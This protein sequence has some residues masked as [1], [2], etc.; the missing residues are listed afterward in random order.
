MAKKTIKPKPNSLRTAAYKAKTVAIESVNKYAYPVRPPDILPGVVPKGGKAPVIAMDYNPGYGQFSQYAQTMVGF[1]GFSYLSML[2]TRPEYRAFAST[3]STE[4][5]R[6]WIEFTSKQDDDTDSNDKIKL[7][8]DEFKRLNVMGAI[9]TAAAHDCLFGRAQLFID[10]KGADRKTP[11]ILDPRTIKKDSLTR[12]SPVEAIWTTPSR[13]NSIDPAAPDFYKP[14]NWF[15]LGQEVH[16][17]RLMTVV[18]RPLPDLLKPAFNFAGMSMSQLAEPYVDNWL[19]TR[20]S[21]ADLINNFSITILSTSMD[22]VLQG[23]DDG[24]D[25]FA[26]ADLFTATRSNRGL[27]LVDKDR[28][29]VV[30]VNTPLSGLS[31]LQAQSQEQMS[32]VSRI[33]TVILTGLSPTGLNA[34]SE[35]E[36]RV[37]YDW[38]AAQQESFWR[39]PIETI[40]KVVQLN[41]FGSIDPDIGFTFVPLFQLTGKEL[42]EVR[43][44]DGVTDVGYVNAGILSQE[45]VRAK[46]AKDPES[47]YQGIDV[48][49]MPVLPELP[50]EPPEDPKVAGD[51]DILAHDAE[52]NESDH[53]RADNGE[54]SKGGYS[55]NMRVAVKQMQDMGQEAELGTPGKFKNGASVPASFYKGKVYVNPAAYQFWNDP[56]GMMN[57]NKESGQLSSSHPL[58][59]I[60]HEIGHSKYRTKATRFDVGEQG[61]VRKEVGNYAAKNP[62]EF[63]A[64]VHAG[65]HGGTK[66]SADIMGLFKKYAGVDAPPNGEEPPDEG[67]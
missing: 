49:D 29:E 47:G 63:L 18:T 2:A 32:S 35:G 39:E 3:L 53:P 9:Q 52:F 19:R 13:Y 28:E 45:E 5:T 20:Q 26:R 10:I 27:M 22:Q 8:E 46:L 12:I 57:T 43:A 21:V 40:L 36:I 31:E 23:S 59:V 55:K 42:S 66:F 37:F 54:F 7:I 17:S 34:S 38:I 51:C 24:T 44:A 16:A 30:Q 62:N 58:H 41:L 60:H 67:K 64:E 61:L 4:I 6:E 50:D 11:L 14:D 1:P 48:G 33:P 65:L 25:L 15:M 56:V